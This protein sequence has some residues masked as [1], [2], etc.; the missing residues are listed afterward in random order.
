[1]Q[2]NFLQNS[3]TNIWNTENLLRTGVN[4]FDLPHINVKEGNQ[5]LKVD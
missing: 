2:E 4:T 3:A 1:M 5:K